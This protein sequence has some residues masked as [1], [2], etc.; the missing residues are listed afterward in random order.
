[1][2][3]ERIAF[4][5]GANGGIGKGII[6]SLIKEKIK[7]IY[8]VR[9]KDKNFLNYVSKN[10]KYIIEVLEFDLNNENETKKQIFSLYKKY[11]KIDFLINNAGIASGA[12]F[13]MTSIKNL[14]NIFE[15]NF[16]SQIRITQLLLRLLKKSKNASI[17]NIGS[18]TGIIPEKGTMAYGS[19]KSALMFS[20][21]VMANE[22]ALYN[23]RVNALAPNVVKTKML[24]LMSEKSKNDLISQSFLNRVC[25][26]KDI[27][28]LVIF[29]CSDK[30]SYINGQI[31]KLNGGMKI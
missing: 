5:T 8:A 1:M 7:I 18:I 29:L 9:K 27:S 31:L 26:T 13:E 20:T 30:S 3:N 22:L 15:I 4:I 21:K 16:F 17:I 24:K 6:N 19:S 28:E 14:K 11:K 12:L 23:I 10:R 2:L 25:S